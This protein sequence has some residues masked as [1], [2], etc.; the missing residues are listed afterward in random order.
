MATILLTGGTGFIG[1][2]LTEMLIKQNYSVII[3]TRKPKPSSGKVSYA[4]WDINAGTIDEN[5]VLAAD[6]IIHLAGAGVAD[7]KW[8]D[9]RKKEIV[10]SRV[11][12]GELLVSVLNKVPHKVK[13]FVSASAIGWYGTDPHIPNREPFQEEHTH[14]TSF[15]GQTCYLWERSLDGLDSKIRLV[16]LRTGIVLGNGGGAYAEFEKPVK[17]GVAAVLGSGKQII[18][19]IHIEDMCREYLYAIENEEVSGVYNAVAPKPVSNKELTITIAKFLKGSFYIPVNVPVFVLKLMLGDRSVEILKSATVS[20]DKMH[21]QGFT[22]LYPSI[23]SAVA[24]LI[25]NR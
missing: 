8:T 13:A 5:A 9:K 18:S 3:L 6:Y 24:N 25:K 7:K 17:M 1:R 11:K 21:R 16:K 20:T 2:A 15:L 19:W 10:D 4:A 23:E 22:F 14:D 12:S